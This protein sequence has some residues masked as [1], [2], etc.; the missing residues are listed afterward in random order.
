MG[1]DKTTAD[2]GQVVTLGVLGAHGGAGTTTLARALGLPELDLARAG[3][4][5]VVVLVAAG[6]GHGGEQLVRTAAALGPGPRIVVALTSTGWWTAPGTR[7]ACRL[8]ADRA[9][10]VVRLPWVW[11][12]HDTTPTTDTATARWRRAALDLA[13]RIESSTTSPEGAHQ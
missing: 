8:L 1:Y 2:G 5:T 6:H 3:H 10:A 9:E 7:G 4:A 13:G 12:W 11:R